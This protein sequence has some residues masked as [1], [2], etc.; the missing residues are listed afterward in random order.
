MF[1]WP[2]RESD[3][4][5][6]RA[7]T[8]SFTAVTRLCIWVSFIPWKRRLWPRKKPPEVRVWIVR[9]L[10]CGIMTV[11]IAWTTPIAYLRSVLITLVPTT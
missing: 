7:G 10:I 4:A 3:V 5:D 9:E 6:A 8:N 2:E 11:S 1:F